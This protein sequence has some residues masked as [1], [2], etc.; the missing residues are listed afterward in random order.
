MEVI[1][2]NKDVVVFPWRK[3]EPS[4]ADTLYPLPS[5]APNIPKVSPAKCAPDVRFVVTHYDPL[6]V[7]RKNGGY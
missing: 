4:E 5:E 3:F 1:V 6:V 7:W 2:T